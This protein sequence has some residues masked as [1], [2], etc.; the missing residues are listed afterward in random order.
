M[1]VSLH[2]EVE[3]LCGM[4]L[5]YICQS[6]NIPDTSQTVLLNSKATYL[7]V[8]EFPQYVGCSFLIHLIFNMDELSINLPSML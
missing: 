4:R 2:G 6:R 8:H 5:D 3:R 7:R 1:F